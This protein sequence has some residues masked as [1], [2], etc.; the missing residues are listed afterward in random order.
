MSYEYLLHVLEIVLSLC[1]LFGVPTFILWW[2]GRRKK[3]SEKRCYRCGRLTPL[4]RLT[5]FESVYARYTR[6]VY[7]CNQC[8]H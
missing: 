5:K 3:E 7:T 2:S 6:V 1:L 4:S 8:L